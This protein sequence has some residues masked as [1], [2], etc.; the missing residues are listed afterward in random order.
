MDSTKKSGNTHGLDS[1][2]SYIYPA[3]RPT[4]ENTGLPIYKMKGL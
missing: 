3:T 1:Y 4:T 2:M